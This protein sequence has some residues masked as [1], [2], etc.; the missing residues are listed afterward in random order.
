MREG[1]ASPPRGSEEALLQ[2]TMI[3]AFKDR[4]SEDTPS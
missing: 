4:P 3:W 2:V 1:G